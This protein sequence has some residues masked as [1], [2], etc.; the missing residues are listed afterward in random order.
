MSKRR[1]SALIRTALAGLVLALLATGCGARHEPDGAAVAQFPLTVRDSSG[2]N[3]AVMRQPM[4]IF[5]LDPAAART[6]LDLGAPSVV[7]SSLP[8][9]KLP[10]AAKKG[11][12]D[13]VVASIDDDDNDVTAVGRA[14]GAPVYRYGASAIP[15]LPAAI[16]QLGTAIGRGPSGVVQA[17]RA[18]AAI[19]AIVAAVAAKPRVR[20]LLDGGSFLAYGPETAAGRILAF[21]GG[22]NVVKSSR[23]LKASDIRPLA[24]AAWFLLPGVRTDP[25][26]LANVPGAAK[27]PAIANKRYVRLDNLPLVSTPEVG[28]AL[29]DIV[30]ELHGGAG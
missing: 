6:L 9:G 25:R 21:A 4:R 18:R 30:R 20:V 8:P 2:A 26:E 23:Q 17:S 29:A 1:V 14:V 24:P 5:A 3:V 7:S 16:A 10:A 28:D 19:A 15:S 22:S 13:L 12:F 11:A 27:V